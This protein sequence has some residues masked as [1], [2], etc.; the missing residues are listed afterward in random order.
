MSGEKQ[1]PGLEIAAPA[2]RMHE[3]EAI[4]CEALAEGDLLG[5]SR[6]EDPRANAGRQAEAAA[7]RVY[8]SPRA[9][10][11]G[12]AERLEAA[13]R[14]ALPEVFAGGAVRIT[15]FSLPDDDWATRW[16][17]FFRPLRVGRRLAILPS[18]W[19]E[20]EG[21][22]AVGAPP[23]EARVLRIEPGRAFGLGAHATTQLALRMLEGLARPGV[24]VL[25]FGAGSGILS[26]AAVL[27]GAGPVVA[28]EIDPECLDNFRDNA[29]INRM[30]GR[31]D[32]R[33]G[34]SEAI[35]RGEEF[36][37]IVCNVLLR[38]VRDPLREIVRCLAPMGSLALSGFLAEELPE[39]EEVLRGIGLAARE[40]LSLGEWSAV[41]A[42][43]KSA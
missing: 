25:D 36:D 37:L 28:V 1:W 7:L 14:R 19:D 35:R 43:G 38:N 12:C 10:P 33:I 30:E 20:A 32:Y 41:V 11:K 8:L 2:H 4:V 40:T 15:P 21:L 16:R 17:E 5:T 22:R 29:R 13:L 23:N 26:F 27:L 31:V 24:R 3:V 42:T 18:W 34:S 39:V 6:E 9:D